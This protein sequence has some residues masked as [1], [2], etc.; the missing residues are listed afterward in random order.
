MSASNT[1]TVKY[2]ISEYANFYPSHDTIYKIKN[3]GSDKYLTVHNGTDANNTNVY[4]YTSSSGAKQQFK[5]EVLSG[6]WRIF[7]MC[8][9][10]GTNRVLDIVKSM[11]IFSDLK[12]F[13]Y[14]FK[15]FRSV[16]ESILSIFI[17]SYISPKRS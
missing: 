13:I 17:K 5:M 3:V 16:F 2:S 6:V 8:S 9:S 14:F 1:G 11:S 15:V 10:N 12:K 7:P 4:Q